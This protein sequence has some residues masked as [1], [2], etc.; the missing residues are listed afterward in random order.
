MQG[1]LQLL[2]KASRNCS[3]CGFASPRG[4][5][6]RLLLLGFGWP[7]IFLVVCVISLG[8]IRTARSDSEGLPPASSLKGEVR[9]GSNGEIIVV[10]PGV[11]PAPAAAP[12]PAAA[13]RT[14]PPPSPMRAAAP[15]VASPQPTR[16]AKVAVAKPRKPASPATPA[17]EDLDYRQ[18]CASPGVVFCHGFDET[19][20]INHFEPQSGAFPDAIGATDGGY[21]PGGVVTQD[22]KDPTRIGGLRRK[23]GDAGG[24]LFRGRSGLR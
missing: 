15:A 19:L 9:R 13:P 5:L 18:R 12:V 2:P 8:P 3:C 6:A 14:S 4:R 23:D 1:R 17:Q 11:Q 7:V 24:F 22:D 20:A 21:A 16:P 10:P